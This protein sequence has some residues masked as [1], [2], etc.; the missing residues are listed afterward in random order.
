MKIF[1]KSRSNNKN[2]G[3]WVGLDP[4]REGTHLNDYLKPDDKL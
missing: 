3:H 2:G 4:Y 1:K